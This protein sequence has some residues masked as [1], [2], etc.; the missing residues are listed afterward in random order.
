MFG[1]LRQAMLW[2]HGTLG[3]AFAGLLLL[4]FFMGSLALYDSE[5]DRWM[6]PETRLPPAPVA[7]LDRQVL[8]VVQR[9]TAGQ[10]LEQWYVEL[11]SARVPA[12]R[13]QSWDLEGEG[14]SH[15]LD[16]RDG[17][18]LKTDGSLGGDFFYRLHYS[19]YLEV[20]RSGMLLVGL[21]ALAGL[22][23]IVAGVMIHAR[24]FKDFFTLRPEKPLRR[25][26]DLH[27]L[28]GVLALPFH[29]GILLTG[30]VIQ[31][32]LLLPAGIL[33]VYQDQAGE[34]EAEARAAYA[35]PALGEPGA[36]ASLDAMAQRAKALWQAGEPAFLRVWHPGDA[37]AYVEIS[38]SLDDRLNLD[39]D[40]LYFGA[41]DGELLHRS[42]L[43]PA[44]STY[45]LLA[46]L[47]VAH[48]QHPLLR[49]LYFLAG[50]SG[51]LMLASGLLYWVA[52]RRAKGQPVRAMAAFN[53]ALIGG[54][55][56]ATLGMLVA[57]RLLPATLEPR[58]SWEVAVFVASWSLAALH[59]LWH[60]W[61][62][63][64]ERGLW[65][66]QSFAIAALALLALGLNGWSTGDHL[67]RS[68]T[69][70]QWAVAGVDLLLL[71][72]ALLASW[73]GRRLARPAAARPA[74][75]VGAN[76]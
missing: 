11:P 22:L 74:L 71:L 47:H 68:L 49:V 56:L 16:P 59:A 42:R 58:A 19:L 12:L 69:S 41:A 6:L 44:A 37:N 38:R 48:F 66:Q 54:L 31:F 40:T 26:L 20:G 65:M 10:A 30:L 5:L 55:P 36:L 3:L 28:S 57:N 14:R 70:G 8:P 35:R 29:L 45:S 7:S 61:R 23:A 53:G 2:L 73:N 21:A 9:L 72:T 15:F 51:C 62:A 63:A 39:G 24:L 46:G 52:K 1:T 17:R 32:P 50:L 60:V 43:A 25:L 67:L 27:N 64:D 4:V 75:E 18:V 13:L 76:A 33:A 34:F